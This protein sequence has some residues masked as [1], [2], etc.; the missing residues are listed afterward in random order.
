M[1]LF[2]S[3][4]EYKRKT[5]FLYVF[6]CFIHK[7]F[8]PLMLQQKRHKRHNK[9]SIYNYNNNIDK[10]RPQVL[11]QKKTTTTTRKSYCSIFIHNAKCCEAHESKISTGIAYIIVGFYSLYFMHV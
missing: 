5:R 10:G 1:H 4:H 7:V 3:S 6:C 2:N 9:K 11:W 8:R